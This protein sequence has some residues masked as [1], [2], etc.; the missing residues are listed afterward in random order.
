MKEE[1]MTQRTTTPNQ[2]T[3]P[4][5][6]RAV[7]V[8]LLAATLLL[9]ISLLVS[10]AEPA[11]VVLS[12]TKTDSLFIDA[13][14]DGLPNAGDTLLYQV[15][16]TNT[17]DDPATGGLFADNPDVDA[18]LVVGS[19]QT[20]QGTIIR[21]N[22]P[23][24]TDVYVDTGD[25]LA[26]STMTISFQAEITYTVATEVSNQGLIS[27]TEVLPLY[28]DDPDTPA[29]DDPTITPLVYPTILVDKILVAADLDDMHPNF[30]TFTITVSNIGPTA[31]DVLP[32][33]DEYDPYYLSFL[34]A[35][36]YP[37][38]DADDGRLT[39]YDLTGTSPNGFGYN[40][41]SGEA[42]IIDTV[43]SVT[44][45]I[46]VTVNLAQAAGALDEFGAPL[47]SIYT[48]AVVVNVPTAA[49]V[50]YFRTDEINGRKV[51]LEWATATE[52]DNVGFKL[53]RTSDSMHG[54]AEQVAYIP[55]QAHGSGAIYTHVDT[56]PQPGSWWYWLVDVDTSGQETLQGAV[57]VTVDRHFPLL[58]LPLILYETHLP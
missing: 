18:P 36:T 50:L 20:S 43:F 47:G 35:T 21:G 24:D 4:W 34:D 26:Y 14:G 3:A 9:L 52:V 32:L 25:I 23:G 48:E 11:A 7:L 17:G 54:Q 46:T 2:L 56:V 55:S 57:K 49:E 31:I 42:F 6:F 41:P 19:V 53:Y 40:L 38:E 12:A 29:S 51:Q 58:Y 10:R 44:H 39:W 15:V 33:Y 45:D 13:N 16:I 28:T 27:T 30:V 5:R 22:T 8:I 37:E 1:N